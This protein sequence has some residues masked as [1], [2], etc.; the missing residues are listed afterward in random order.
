VAA[1]P[2]TASVLVALG[3]WIKLFPGLLGGSLLLR[4][5]W[6]AAAIAVAVGLAL[7]VVSVLA[8]GWEP[9]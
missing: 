1:R 6:R 8:L 2:A 9:H 3:A 4:R 7:A 5:Q